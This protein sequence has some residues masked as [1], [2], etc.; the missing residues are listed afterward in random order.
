MSGNCW[1]EPPT[2]HN[3][4]RWRCVQDTNDQLVQRQR[5]QSS[6]GVQHRDAQW[7]YI[8]VGYHNGPKLLSGCLPGDDKCECMYHDRKPLGHCKKDADCRIRFGLDS[9]IHCV[10]PPFK[11]PL[12]PPLYFAAR[13]ATTSHRVRSLRDRRRLQV[14]PSIQA[15]LQKRRLRRRERR[16]AITVAVETGTNLNL[17]GRNSGRT[18]PQWGIRFGLEGFEVMDLVPMPTP[19]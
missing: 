16:K 6:D 18:I 9:G 15:T 5:P 19:I 12:N 10:S 17:G 3:E 14:I 13:P 11:L 1:H 4:R 2:L 8:G 7:E